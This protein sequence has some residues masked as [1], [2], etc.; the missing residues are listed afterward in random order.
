MRLYS[1]IV[2]RVNQILKEKKYTQKELARRLGKNPSEIHRWLNGEHNFTLRSLAKLQAELDELILY[3]PE[4]KTTAIYIQG[5]RKT[6]Q[7]VV[8]KTAM[9]ITGIKFRSKWET[10][11]QPIQKKLANA[12]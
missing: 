1:S 6:C 2:I 11:K 5:Q 4:R 9:V 12:G 10:S 7:T 8:Y 3:V